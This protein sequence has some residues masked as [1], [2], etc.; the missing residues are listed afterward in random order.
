MVR[1]LD[2]ID[3]NGMNRTRGRNASSCVKLGSAISTTMPPV[4]DHNETA[5][6]STVPTGDGAPDPMTRATPWSNR[7]VR[8][9]ETNFFP[10]AIKRSTGASMRSV[11]IECAVMMFGNVATKSDRRA[12]G[13]LLVA[14]APIAAQHTAMIG[15]GGI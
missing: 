4:E 7:Q 12:G 8:R 13:A 10:L 1:A 11:R 9:A 6:T 5:S 2:R 15:G 3:V 14:A